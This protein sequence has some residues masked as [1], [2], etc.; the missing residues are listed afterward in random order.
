MKMLTI[1]FRA[2]LED[3][4]QMLLGGLGITTYTLIRG[5]AG[6]GEAGAY[7]LLWQYGRSIL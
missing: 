4:M 6:S 3:E 5:I 7:E 2:G 1:I